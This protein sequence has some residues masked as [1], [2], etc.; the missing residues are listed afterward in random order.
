M[1]TEL[2]RL[3]TQIEQ[4]ITLYTALRDENRDLRAHK[5]RLETENRQLMNK[6][7]LAA[8][9]LEAVLDRLPQ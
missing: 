8:E 2:N 5:S 7:D 1:D 3:E 9:K 6:I 4:L